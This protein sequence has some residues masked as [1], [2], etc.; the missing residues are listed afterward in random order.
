MPPAS[1]AIGESKF[2]QGMDCRPGV[3]GENLQTF[4]ELVN[5]VVAEDG[6]LETRDPCRKM[7][8]AISPLA[9][10][11]VINDGLYYTIARK[12]DTITHTGAVASFVNTLYFDP[13][14]NVGTTWTL[15]CYE[16]FQNKV[17]AWIRHTFPGLTITTRLYQHTWDLLVDNPTYIADPS[18]LWDWGPAGFPINAYG[19]GTGS[20]GQWTDYSPVI[21]PAAEKMWASRVDRNVGFS[22]ISRARIWN[23]SSA[24]TIEKLG[25]MYYFTVPNASLT[26]YAIPETYADFSDYQKFAGYVLERLNADG[27]WTKI[28]ESF[29]A[30]TS[31]QYQLISTTRAWSTKTIAA[32]YANGL[33]V[34]S[35]IRFR[36][37]MTP[38]VVI[39]SG[40]IITPGS[41]TY[42]GDGATVQW[43]STVPF[44]AFSA[45]EVRVNSVTKPITTYYAVTN[46]SGI[47]RVDF[48]DFSQVTDG[49]LTQ[50]VLTPGSG[51]TSFPAIALVGGTGGGGASAVVTSLKAVSAT[52]AVG[53]AGYTNGDTLTI[54]GDTGTA[55]TFTATVAAGV[56]TAVTVLAPGA[57][58]VIAANP[59]A[60]TGGTGAGCTLNVSFGVNAVTVT[61]GSGYV[62]APTTNFSGGAGAGAALTLT[63]ASP[64]GL[65]SV[66]YA[67]AIDGD[68]GHLSVYFNGAKKTETTDY[69]LS[70]NAGNTTVTP[71]TALAVGTQLNAR[72]VVPVD[73]LIQFVAA[74]LALSAGT[75]T[76]EQVSQTSPA[77]FISS[78]AVSS[79]YY[80]A[81]TA[82][83]VVSYKLTSAPWTGLERYQL[84]IVGTVTTDSG[85]SI[86]ATTVFKYGNQEL[87]AWYNARHQLNLDYWAGVNEGGFI[88]SGTHDNSGSNV[89]GMVAVKNRMAI[90]YQQSTQLWQVDPVPTNCAFIDRYAFGSRYDGVNFYSRPLIYTQKGFR[91]FDLEGLNFQSLSDV[92]IGE[93]IQQLGKLSVRCATFW[94]WRGSYIAAC[95]LTG[96][97]LY[98]AN[99]GLPKSSVL[100]QASIP[101]FVYLSF[102]K[103]SG[104]SAW[105]IFTVAGLT[106]V[107][108]MIPTDGK[109]YCLQGK[110]IWYFD[111]EIAAFTDGET[112]QLQ[113]SGSAAWHLV[114]LGGAA[115]SV[116]LLHVDMI[117]QG[118]CQINTSMMPWNASNETPGP[119]ML[120]STNGAARV[121][122]RSTG[123]AAGVHLL[124]TDPAGVTVQSVT[125]EYI[126]LGR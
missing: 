11:I 19:S 80:V 91:A 21:E 73:T 109:V 5:M 112:G 83:G 46:A 17:V 102:S 42:R 34:D 124:T 15:V 48:R 63:L 78:L 33:T 49:Q 94:P 96:S 74:T 64:V 122:L 89:T 118:K 9:Q 88:N 120:Q 110:D 7:N 125:I 79:T 103:E 115:K 55:T 108:T 84:H 8:G 100:Y 53:G 2:S 51:Y 39:A 97:A 59:H 117:K 26:T 82:N 65:T 45:Y 90:F 10:G 114:P 58:T 50:N 35:L 44:A 105:S 41:E 87:T 72:L 36:V 22:G 4:R 62:T 69:V 116:R 93:P 54:T 31:G 27:S 92:N 68:F 23:S 71:T 28:T 47:A 70:N 85:G 123:R 40:S 13:P 67:A 29:S 25:A 12:G 32:I 81:A 75:I 121:P 119:T 77:I 95:T 107:D 104:I 61:P 20:S 56:V 37:L 16:V 43:P 86:S 57:K 106:A 101:C 76:Y 14:E 18:G 98:A 1:K 99:A 24:A 52:V 126:P 3:Q 30:P 6:S 111:N 113:P 60:T 38:E 66:P